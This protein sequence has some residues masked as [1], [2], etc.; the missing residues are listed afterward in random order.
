MTDN[1]GWWYCGKYIN[2]EDSELIPSDAVGFV[3]MIRQFPDEVC[4]KLIERGI[5]MELPGTIKIY[6]G[7]KSLT[8]TRKSKI[9]VRAQAKQKAET[10]DGRVKKVQRITKSSGWLSYNSSCKPLIENMKEHP[11]LYR[12]EILQWCWS[13]K[14]LSYTEELWQY[15]Y[16]VLEIDSWNDNIGGTYYKHDASKQKWEAHKEKMKTTP[17]VRKPKV[18]KEIPY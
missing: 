12:K 1:Q 4:I 8:S 18:K 13:K 3:Y 5:H 7:K 2:S 17:R 15:K 10:G 16:R 6:I 9:G 14:N 11:E